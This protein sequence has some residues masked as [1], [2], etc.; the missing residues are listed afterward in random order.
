MKKIVTALVAV[1]AT[2]AVSASVTTTASAGSHHAWV[3]NTSTLNFRKG[4]PGTYKYDHK[5]AKLVWCQRVKV[6]HTEWFHGKKW[7][8]V[9][10]NG[11]WGWASAGY[12]SDNNSHCKKRKVHKKVRKHIKNHKYSY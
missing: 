12:L 1:A 9:H 6:S 11:K 5:M 7:A 2:L 8:K 10:A 3:K 4:P